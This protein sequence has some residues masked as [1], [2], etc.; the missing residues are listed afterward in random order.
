M[1]A[2]PKPVVSH[3]RATVSAWPNADGPCLVCRGVQVCP[4]NS[5]SPSPVMDLRRRSGVGPRE[6]HNWR[7]VCEPSCKWGAGWRWPQQAQAQAPFTVL[8]LRP[9]ILAGCWPVVVARRPHKAVCVCPGGSWTPGGWSFTRYLTRYA[10]L[11]PGLMLK[12]RAPSDSRA[13]CW[14]LL[15]VAST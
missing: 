13:A 9:L 3:C 1:H 14:T 4:T 5:N 2:D 10:A 12:C 6:T 15:D 8:G 7:L 11:S